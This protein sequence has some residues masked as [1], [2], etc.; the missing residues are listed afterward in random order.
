MAHSLSFS[1]ILPFLS[2]DSF[3]SQLFYLTTTNVSFDMIHVITESP[4]VNF[5]PRVNRTFAT[6]PPK[7]SIP[8]HF[9]K[10]F[11]WWEIFPKN[12]NDETFPRM[13][14]LKS[15]EL[16]FLIQRPCASRRTCS[17]TQ[18]NSELILLYRFGTWKNSISFYIQRPRVLEK[19]RAPFLQKMGLGK[20][21]SSS[22]YKEAAGEGPSEVRCDSSCI[23]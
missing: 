23:L 12:F 11:L 14:L 5:N 13:G 15:S 8:K 19:F 1:L 16:L 17:T 2:S 3:E 18:T 4:T 6:P 9:S 21:Q 7:N 20:F 10:K 22:P